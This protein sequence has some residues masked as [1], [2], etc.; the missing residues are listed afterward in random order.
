MKGFFRVEGKFAFLFLMQ[1]I[2]V[3][4]FLLDGKIWGCGFLEICSTQDLPCTLKIYG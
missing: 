4:F 3:L 2:S 1:I